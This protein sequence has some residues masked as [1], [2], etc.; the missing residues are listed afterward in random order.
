MLAY[1]DTLQIFH[2]DNGREF[3]NQVLASLLEQ[4]GGDTTFV[5]G[6][7]R[8]SQSQGLVERGNRTI[9]NLTHV[10]KS[11]LVH[12]SLNEITAL[13][14]LCTMQEGA[15]NKLY[16]ALRLFVTQSAFKM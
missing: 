4:W 15:K 5:H 9:Y 7:P 13:F 11:M 16:I 2:S 1:M 6:R 12:V 8:H 14:Q 3:V 10:I